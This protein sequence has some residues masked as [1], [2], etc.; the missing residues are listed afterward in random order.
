MLPTDMQIGAARE[1]ERQ[2]RLLLDE[3]DGQARCG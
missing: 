1:L 2:R 3:K